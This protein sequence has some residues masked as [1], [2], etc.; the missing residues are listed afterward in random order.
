MSLD[1]DPVPKELIVD[2]SHCDYMDSTFM[3]LL[4]GF[5]KK[6]KRL[7]GHPLELLQPTESCR[8]LLKG[9]GILKILKIL[10]EPVPIPHEMIRI[11]KGAEAGVDMVLAAHDELIEL[12]EE[13]RAKFALLQKILREQAKGLD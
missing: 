10:E 2:L 6:I 7:S 1:H 11:E 3:G 8:N 4:I 12:N 13:N 9:L 5:N